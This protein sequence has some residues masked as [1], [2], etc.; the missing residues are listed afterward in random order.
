MTQSIK[1][2][3][4]LFRHL[5]DNSVTPLVGSA[6][7]GL[8]LVLAHMNS[9][10]QQ[11]VLIW[12]IFLFFTVLVRALLTQ[13]YKS[14]YKSKDYER[15]DAMKYAIS[16]GISGLAWGLGGLFIIDASPIVLVVTI[17]AVQAMIMGGALTLAAYMPSFYA[18]SLPAIVPLVA[19]LAFK[20]GTSNIILA[21]FSAIFFLLIISIAK[22]FNQSL[23]TGW[24][25]TFDKEKLLK[26]L[27]KANDYQKA[28]ANTDGL[29]GI[30]NR[31][32][33]DD[34][35]ANELARVSRTTS[36]L[37]LL[38]IDVDH[39]KKFNDN[40]GHVAGDECLKKIAQ[41]LSQH[42]CRASDMAARYGGEEFAVIMPNTDEQ[43]AIQRAELIQREIAALK[44]LHAHSP[45]AEHITLSIGIVSLCNSD[46]RD[47]KNLIAI[48]DKCLYQAKAQGRNRVISTRLAPSMQPDLVAL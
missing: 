9:P 35:L 34:V 7:G 36:P 31:R 20:G 33:F 2:E 43:G 47:T 19:T 28:L 44:I 10:Y 48:A 23:K 24:Q 3:A 5:L 27:T 26:E 8:L 39:F 42:F 25:L 22:R 1:I 38:I 12:L 46:I 13:R 17:T 29:T 40:Y 45:T 15:A 4:A 14:R 37:S 18:F 21:I 16:T 41:I 32:R 6:I 11:Q 30:A